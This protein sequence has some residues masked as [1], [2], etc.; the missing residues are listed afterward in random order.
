MSIDLLK[1]CTSSSRWILQRY[2]QNLLGII[3]VTSESE[4]GEKTFQTVLR[5][6]L[7][8]PCLFERLGDLSNFCMPRRNPGSNGTEET[9]LKLM[10]IL[11]TSFAPRLFFIECLV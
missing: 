6:T 4:T 7:E 10:K 9:S 2:T 11:N 3:C 5:G 1:E 8:C